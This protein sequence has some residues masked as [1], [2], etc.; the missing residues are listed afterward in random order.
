MFADETAGGMKID[1]II[2][3]SSEEHEKYRK[4]TQKIY[5]SWNCAAQT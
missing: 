3:S 5:L 1:K 2:E 4:V